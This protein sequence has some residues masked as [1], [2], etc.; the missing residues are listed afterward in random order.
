MAISTTIYVTESV[1]H[2][3]PTKQ[4]SNDCIYWLLNNKKIIRKYFQVVNK[5]V[6]GSQ[7]TVKADICI[8]K[9]TETV[10]YGI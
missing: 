7:P 9:Y 1:N 2:T 6:T 4:I 5:N 10:L 3:E 8:M